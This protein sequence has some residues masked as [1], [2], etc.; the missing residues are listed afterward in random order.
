[1]RLSP[2]RCVIIIVSC[3]IL[4]NFAVSEN[5]FDFDREINVDG[6][7]MPKTLDQENDAQ[8][9]VKRQTIVQNYFQYFLY[10]FRVPESLDRY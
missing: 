7:I 9:R 8:G 4:H 3:A 5:D 6:D 1:M 2:E 10:H